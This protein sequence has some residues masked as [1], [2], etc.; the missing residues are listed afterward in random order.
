VLETAPHVAN[1]PTH[2]PVKTRTPVPK[3]AQAERREAASP[4]D[5]VELLQAARRAL[6]AQPEQALTLANQHATRFSQGLF[7]EEREAIVIEAL[8]K[9]ARLVQA[10]RALTRFLHDYPQSSYRARLL[11]LHEER[12]TPSP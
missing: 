3:R 5:E 6:L 4:G 11:R 1:E 2:A 9:L 7:V 8:F 12:A 10:E